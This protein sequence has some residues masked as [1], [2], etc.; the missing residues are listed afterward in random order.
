MANEIHDRLEDGYIWEI[1]DLANQNGQTDPT[2]TVRCD[3]Q[4][5]VAKSFGDLGDRI[6]SDG[7]CFW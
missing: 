5:D 2:N 6:R 7:K 1:E 4:L 3:L